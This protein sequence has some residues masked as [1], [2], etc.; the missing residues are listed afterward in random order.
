MARGVI[1]RKVV[2]DHSAFGFIRDTDGNELFFLPS[3]VQRTTAPFAE[4]KEQDSVEFTSI[5][6]PKGMRAIEIRRISEQVKVPA[7]QPHAGTQERR[8]RGRAK[9]VQVGRS[10]RSHRIR[11]ED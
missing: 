4:L 5:E 8:N 10:E 9:M 7:R 6:H 3:G 11:F 2:T 1:I